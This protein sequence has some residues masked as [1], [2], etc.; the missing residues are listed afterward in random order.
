MLTLSAV[1]DHKQITMEK[2][3]VQVGCITSNGTS[4]STR[5]K[6]RIDVGEGLTQRERAILFNSARNCEVGKIIDG[7]VDIDYSLNSIVDLQPY[8]EDINDE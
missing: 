4:P 6:I 2:C 3:E 1:A 7:K 8:C 5:F